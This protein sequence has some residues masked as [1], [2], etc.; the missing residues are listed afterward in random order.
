MK[1]IKVEVL[2]EKSKN[3]KYYAMVEIS[4]EQKRIFG[5]V[6][7]DDDIA[8]EGIGNDIEQ[9]NKIYSYVSEMD[10]SSINL[11]EVIR[12]LRIDFFV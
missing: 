6:V 2:K 11:D 5:F 12:D 4:V 8:I 3:Q 10:I 9:A 7:E 1:N